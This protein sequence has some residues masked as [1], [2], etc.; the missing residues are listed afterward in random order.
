MP[1]AKPPTKAA[2]KT[3]SKK[4]VASKPAAKRKPAKRVQTDAISRLSFEQIVDLLTRASGNITH[5]AR[6][7]GIPRQTFVRR[8]MNDPSLMQAWDDIGEGCVDGVESQ[9]YL[10]AMKG[11]VRA[12]EIFLLKNP[13]AKKRGWGAV[14]EATKSTTLSPQFHSHMH[15]SA[16]PGGANTPIDPNVAKAIA[17][18]SLEQL[19][20]VQEKLAQFP[21]GKN[22]DPVTL[23]VTAV[24]RESKSN[25]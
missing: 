5:A 25:P 20:A 10:T 8:V 22:P 13:R 2:R 11:N 18:A 21:L 19:K 15:L 23:E 14:D 24:V 12:I 6:V 16:N 17:G 3:T 1:R 4:P 9:L 7:A